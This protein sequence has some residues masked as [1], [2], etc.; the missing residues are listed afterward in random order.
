M[1]V[2]RGGLDNDFLF[3]RFHM[4]VIVVLGPCATWTDSADWTNKPM[5]T[6]TRLTRDK[7][8]SIPFQRYL[9]GHPALCLFVASILQLDQV[10][11]VCIPSARSHRSTPH[12][13]DLP[14]EER[15]LDSEPETLGRV[16]Q[17]KAIYISLPLLLGSLYIV[18]SDVLL[19]EQDN[20]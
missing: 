14:S 18:G 9:D 12:S 13:T 20:P 16:C 1:T 15:R 7:E 8:H 4:A 17:R 19:G 3:D 11:I 10:S 5:E 2:I 6:S